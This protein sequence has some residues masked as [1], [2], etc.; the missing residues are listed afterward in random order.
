MTKTV[1]ILVGPKGSG[2]TY[3]GE[4]LSRETS[5]HFL[6]VE[7]IWL[8]LQPDEDGW[9]KVEAAVD[10]ALEEHDAIVIESLGLTSGFERMRDSLSRRHSVEYI[11][12]LASLDAC[13][14][15][16]RARD[17]SRQIPVSEDK[18]RQYNEMAATV[19]LSWSLTI[20]N[21]GPA[22]DDEILKAFQPLLMK[23]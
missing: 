20:D 4:L 8:S 5:V 3:I 17:A 23:A 6:S 12:V 15:R 16:V 7:P 9:H 2:K 19:E 22:D 11:R 14:D 21:S 18:V 13:L 1:Y 10:D